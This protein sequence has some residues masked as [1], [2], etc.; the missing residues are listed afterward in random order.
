MH[1]RVIRLA[2][3]DRA[4]HTEPREGGMRRWR[5]GRVVVIV[6]VG[7]GYS[8]GEWAGSSNSTL[9]VIGGFPTATINLMTPDALGDFEPDRWV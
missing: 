7:L 8:A 2:S 6:A 9:H 4:L 3:V 5:P 1:R